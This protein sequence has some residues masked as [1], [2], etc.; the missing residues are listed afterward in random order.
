MV[1]NLVY[2]ILPQ[3]LSRYKRAGKKRISADWNP[4][5]NGLL[6]RFAV[7]GNSRDNLERKD[8]EHENSC[9]QRGQLFSEVSAH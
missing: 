1:L 7:P 8:R 9:H 6:G 3:R 2:L 4:A 5:G